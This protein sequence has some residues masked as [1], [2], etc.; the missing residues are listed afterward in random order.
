MLKFN[1]E[2]YKNLRLEDRREA[3]RC[4]KA[5]DL[6]L[7]DPERRRCYPM[8]AFPVDKMII[9]KFG[10]MN[11]INMVRGLAPMPARIKQWWMGYR[12]VKNL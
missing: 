4:F 11:N 8:I 1:T 6:P 10:Y 2:M 9:W 12:K 3:A 5:M 7:G